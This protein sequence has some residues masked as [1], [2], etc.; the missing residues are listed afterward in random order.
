MIELQ[1][2]VPA[3][4][5]PNKNRLQRLGVVIPWDGMKVGDNFTIPEG[6]ET[7][8]SAVWMA[9]SRRGYKVRT[10][11]SPHGLQVWRVG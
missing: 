4:P 9:A 10:G 5:P 6:K 3:P 1:N 8:R 7:D 11:M 2:G